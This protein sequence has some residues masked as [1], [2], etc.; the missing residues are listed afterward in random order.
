M[1]NWASLF[2]RYRTPLIVA[3]GGAAAYG[4]WQRTQ[5]AN[6][7]RAAASVIAAAPA[8]SSA[9]LTPEQ[10]AALLAAGGAQ[11]LAGVQA[12]LGPTSDALSLGSVAIQGAQGISQAL[13][14]QIGG[15]VATLGSLAGQ[16]I[17]VLPSFAPVA[18]IAP[19][20]T[21][22]A[23]SGPTGI[24]TPIPAPSPAATR[25]FVGYQV[26][27]PPGSYVLWTVSS[28]GALTNH[29]SNTWAAASTAPVARV[30]SG[31]TLYWRTLAGGYAGWSYVPGRSGP[32]QV[33]RVYRWSDG[34]MEYV[35]IPVTGS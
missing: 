8:G 33:R 4:A 12:G 13:T 16:A 24:G 25:S 17:S 34:R 11:T 6:Q 31:P 2:K 29:R 5:A 21:T 23:P 10:T 22:V 30:V 3:G 1:A 14:G 19:Q 9:G 32:F 20:S 7:A 35:S 15:A 28:A 26:Y 18:G 27:L